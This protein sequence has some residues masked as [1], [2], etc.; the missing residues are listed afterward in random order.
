MQ[1]SYVFNKQYTWEMC[2]QCFLDF[3]SVAIYPCDARFIVIQGK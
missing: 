3:D 1:I 2:I